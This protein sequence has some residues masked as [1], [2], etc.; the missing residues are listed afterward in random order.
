MSNVT[1]MA[2][3]FCKAKSFNQNI[4]AWD[5]SSV[6]NMRSMFYKAK[7]FNQPLDSWDVSNVTNMAMM[8]EGSPTKCPKWYDDK[9]VPF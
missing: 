9:E 8:F 3:M 2:M 1:D 6:T 5:V 7:S 4:N